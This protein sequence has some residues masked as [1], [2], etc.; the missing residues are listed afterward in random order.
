MF[1]KEDGRGSAPIFY[2][3]ILPLRESDT[4]C[5]GRASSVPKR[6]IIPAKLTPFHAG[7]NALRP[8][9]VVPREGERKFKEKHGCYFYESPA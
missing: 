1:I 3:I 2:G 7:A 9:R 8:F 4:S 5:P 6:V